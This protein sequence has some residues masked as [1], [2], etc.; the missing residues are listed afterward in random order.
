MSGR[1][2]A[3]LPWVGELVSRPKCALRGLIAP[4]A[5]VLSKTAVLELFTIG[6]WSVT[7]DLRVEAN[8][9]DHFR[10]WNA[11]RGRRCV[12]VVLEPRRHVRARTVW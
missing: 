9:H 5:R 11:S 10:S 1:H 6:D 4:G 3:S 7:G 2:I 8:V 12:N